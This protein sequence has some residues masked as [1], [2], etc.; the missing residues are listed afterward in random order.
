MSAR[1]PD[2]LRH[3][4]LF[5]ALSGEGSLSAAAAQ[6]GLSQPAASQALAALERRAGGALFVRRMGGALTARGLALQPRLARAFAILDRGFADLAPRLWLTTSHAQLRALIAAVE[7]GSFALAAARLGVKP[8]SVQRAIATL[9]AEA[10]RALFTRAGQGMRASRAAQSLSRAARLALAELAQAEAELAAIDG[11]ATG[12]I[13]VGALPLARAAWLPAALAD[14]RRRCPGHAVAIIDGAYPALIDALQRTEIDMV[15]GALRDPAPGGDIRQ[16]RVFDDRLAL[17]AAPGHPALRDDPPDLAALARADWV[18]PRMGAPGRAQFDAVFTAVG[19]APPRDVVE[20]GSVVI[21]RELAVE[22]GYLGC[23]S[24]AQLGPELRRG[25]LVR[26]P[27]GDD[28][29]ARPIGIATRI[30]WVPTLAQQTLLDCLDDAAP[31]GGAST[32]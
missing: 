20:A 17:V 28:L 32:P 12:P 8:P 16:I 6:M 19:L 3:L 22:A 18:V 13:R 24:G 14:F 1:L 2:N 29:P 25:Q 10:G 7:N 5:L 23:I 26:L 4:R 31:K 11:V 27:I 9:E 21:L 15:L 30:G